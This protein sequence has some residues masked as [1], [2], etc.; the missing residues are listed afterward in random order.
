[1]AL[2]TFDSTN[3]HIDPNRVGTEQTIEFYP[4]SPNGFDILQSAQIMG[5]RSEWWSM[6]QQ[7]VEVCQY[8]PRSEAQI[9]VPCIPE[10][11]LIS[12]A[13][14]NGVLIYGK[15]YWDEWHSSVKFG[16]Q[17]NI[18]ATDIP[19]IVDYWHQDGASGDE[20]DFECIL[21]DGVVNWE[22]RALANCVYEYTLTFTVSLVRTLDQDNFGAFD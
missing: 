14:G 22:R 4:L 10:D 1:M 7:T 11:R 3:R 2:I 12:G 15:R 19:G 21:K 5:N 9:I 17:F 20:Y 18:D 8:E 13:D 6:D 16:Q